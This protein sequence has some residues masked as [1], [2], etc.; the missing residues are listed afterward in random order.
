MVNLSLVSQSATSL[1]I[2][3]TGTDAST[4]N[5][6]RRALLSDVSVPVM[7]PG[8]GDVG[9]IS[10]AANTSL[11]NNEILKQRLA[12]VPVNLSPEQ[13]EAIHEFEGKLEMRNTT[14]GSIYCT[15]SDITWSR[16]G[17]PLSKVENDAI[18]PVCQISGRP[19]RLLALRPPIPPAT[20]GE[21]LEFTVRL[22]T[23]SAAEDA[24]FNVVSKS[25][26][27][28]VPDDA[29]GRTGWTA[30]REALLAED[31]SEDRLATAE[32]DWYALE[33]RRLTVPGE[34]EFEAQSV[35]SYDVASLLKRAASAVIS[36]LN[37]AAVAV[38]GAD[39]PITIAAVAMANAWDVELLNE[40]HTLGGII[41]TQIHSD[42]T[43]NGLTYC[44]FS[45]PHPQQPRS[46][47]RLAFADPVTKEDV[48]RLLVDQIGA[49]VV[50]FEAVVRQLPD[51]VRA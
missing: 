1:K 16:N 49:A 19:I 25:T 12:C 18:L 26:F 22:K 33:A 40:D 23:G 3:F 11:T 37:N 9:T 4:V 34:F 36:R 45:R 17:V 6:L 42:L 7:H 44:G 2:R 20:V 50:N 5:A 21:T 39:A 31:T 51:P 46:V 41:E 30:K 43:R 38:G 47:L 8:S 10:V 29:Q 13:L 14:D 28:A 27:F 15:T 35:G 32:R 48:S 24:C